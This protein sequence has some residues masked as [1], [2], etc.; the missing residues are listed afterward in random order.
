MVARGGV[1][2]QLDPSLPVKKQIDEAPVAP[3]H[4]IRITLTGRDVP[5]LEEGKR[6]STR[7]F[8][9]GSIYVS[10]LS[11]HQSSLCFAGWEL[12]LNP[13]RLGGF[14][15]LGGEGGNTEIII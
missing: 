10:L 4:K 7:S 9:T 5:S 3:I 6:S 15:G 1:T 12:G 8:S 14:C 11:I 13:S 2:P